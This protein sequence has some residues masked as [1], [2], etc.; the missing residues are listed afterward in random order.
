[1]DP[2][3]FF[4]NIEE[5]LK[6]LTKKKDIKLFS[7][8][9]LFMFSKSEA[10]AITFP[11]FFLIHNLIYLFLSNDYSH[12]IEPKAKMIRPTIVLPF[13]STPL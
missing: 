13:L 2:G 4:L 9:S 12:N 3:W 6:Y 10:N 11:D 1:M 8:C 7:H 5:V